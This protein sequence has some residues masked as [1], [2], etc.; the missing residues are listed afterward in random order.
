MQLGQ[1]CPPPNSAAIGRAGEAAAIRALQANG[2][3]IETWNTATPGATDIVARG[4]RE[5]IRV[6]V[7]SALDGQPTY[8]SAADLFLLKIIA[9]LT[10][11]TA[12]LC[13]VRLTRI[14]GAMLATAMNWRKIE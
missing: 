10:R 3:Q 13:Q 8:P 2:W 14:G 5:R 7:K 1:L 11:Q 4:L 6:Q 12:Y 9:A